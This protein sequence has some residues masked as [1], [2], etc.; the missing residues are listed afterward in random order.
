MKKIE[1]IIRP[2]KL[3]KVNDA[4]CSYGFIGLTMTQVIGCGK[5][6]GHSR[7]YRDVVYTAKFIPKVKIEIWNVM[8]NLVE[9]II[10]VITKEGRRG[11]SGDGKIFV[12]D[13]KNA[14]RIRTGANR[15]E[16]LKDHSVSLLN[17]YRKDLAL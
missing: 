12:S 7:I 3:D 17:M 14:Y 13:V 8:D 2:S 5:Q 4:L 9:E 11:E 6:K 1:A 10:Q 15:E 16:A